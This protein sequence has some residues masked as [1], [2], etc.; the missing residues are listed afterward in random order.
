MADPRRV[1]VPRVLLILPAGFALMA[2]LNAA[3]LL[4]GLPA[5]VR[6][7]RFA[8]T[9][10]V[11]L[12]LG[13]VGTLIALERAVALGRR[14]GYIAPA[15]LGAGGVLLVSPLPLASGAWLLVLGSALLV[16][17]YVPL[18]RRQ[19]AGAVTIEAG[20]AVVATGAALLW[21]AGV[22]TPWVVP[23][24]AGFLV[25]TIAGERIELAR[26]GHVEQRAESVAML[27]ATALTA[28]IVASLLWPPVGSAL[29]GAA[30][31][32]LVGWLVS[33]DVARRTIRGSGL[34]RFMAGCLLAGYGW[35]AVAGMVWLVSGPQLAGPGYDA[36]VHAVFLGFVLSMI[37]AHAPVI[38]PA[39]LRRPLPYHRAML[40]PAALLHVSLLVRIVGGDARG[41]EWAWQ[42]GGLLNI[43]A[44]LGFAAVAVWSATTAPGR[45]AEVTARATYPAQLMARVAEA[46][47]GVAAE[48]P[49]A[50]EP[51]SGVR[52]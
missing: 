17:V 4:L 46:D 33:H 31:L 44:V 2:G 19:P 42:W 15:T 40:V 43:V 23:W 6:G 5:P 39:V 41:I 1:P 47:A 48:T 7:E 50:V 22:P 36:V 52:R 9:H 28:G 12:V 13:F 8:D 27:L 38:L 37:M 10:G 11:L 14:W 26:V 49:P 21:A 3:L 29:L 35:L 45:S 34:P 20:G 51:A 16:T 25:L 32:G 30:L 24:L 18:W